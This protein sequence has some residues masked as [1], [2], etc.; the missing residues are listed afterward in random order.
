MKKTPTSRRLRRNTM[1]F[2]TPSLL[3]VAVFFVVPFV[4]VIRYAVTTRPV[5][6]LRT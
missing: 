2:V 1:L 6:P 3:G 5:N 4:V